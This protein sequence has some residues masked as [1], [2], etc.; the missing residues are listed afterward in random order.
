MMIFKK[1][2]LGLVDEQPQFTGLREISFGGEQRQAL[3]AVVAVTSHRGRRDCR[4]RPPEAVSDGMHL[5]DPARSWSTAS[6]PLHDAEGAVVV[7]PRSR[8]SGPGFF[9]EIMNTV[10]P[11][12]TRILDQRIVRRQ[13][14]DVILHD[15]GRHDQDRLGLHATSVAGAYWINSISR[16]RKITLPGVIA[17]VLPRL[18]C[19]GSR[20]FLTHDFSLPIL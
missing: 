17:T 9:Q 15:P 5:R 10:C 7:H 8:S 3:Q 20:R 6:Q 4:E 13:I 18:I 19:L 16:L 1:R 14:E 11:R 2:D 12:S